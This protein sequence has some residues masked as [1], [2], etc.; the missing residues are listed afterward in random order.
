MTISCFKR[1]SSPLLTGA[2]VAISVEA[3]S[4]GSGGGQTAATNDATGLYAANKTLR[5]PVEP[6][7]RTRPKREQLAAAFATAFG[8]RTERTVGDNIYRFQTG[9]ITWIGAR[10]ILISPGTGSDDCHACAGTLAVHYLVPEGRGFRVAGEWLE[11]GGFGGYGHSPGWRFSSELSGRPMLRTE[12]GD[13]NQGIFCSWI[14]YYEFAEGGPRE[15]ANVPVGYS[16]A[17]GMGGPDDGVEIEGSI[18]HIRANQSF[19]VAYS[20][21]RTFTERWVMRGGRFVPERGESALPTC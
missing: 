7:L 1:I 16:N 10:A 20:G 5:T 8:S 19:E 14:T 17:S 9:G 12:G 11:G 18:R 4:Q 3:C 13:G 6:A 2:C 21:S 15:I